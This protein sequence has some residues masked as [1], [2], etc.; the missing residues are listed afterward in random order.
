[1]MASHKVRKFAIFAVLPL[2]I[3]TIVLIYPFAQGLYLTFTNWDGFSYTKFTGFTNYIQSF[4]SKE[5]WATL[6]FTKIGRAHV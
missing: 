4:H 5:F 2:A 1:M 3:F 6:I